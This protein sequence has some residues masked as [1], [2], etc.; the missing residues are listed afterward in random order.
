[1]EGKGASRVTGL[2]VSVLPVAILR[3]FAEPT[4]VVSRE[5]R[6][7]SPAPTQLLETVIYV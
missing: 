5:G 1:M 3:Q 4:I 2:E 7:L 6:H